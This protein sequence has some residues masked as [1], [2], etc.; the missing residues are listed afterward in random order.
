MIPRLGRGRPPASLS[1]DRRFATA[2]WWALYDMGF[3]RPYVAAYLAALAVDMDDPIE[4]EVVDEA[5]VVMSSGLVPETKRLRR[6][7]DRLVRRIDELIPKASATELAWL[8]QSA[9]M[10]QGMIHFAARR[11][12]C[13]FCLARDMLAAVDGWRPLIERL[14]QRLEVQL[15]A[16]DWLEYTG[17]LS[18][19]ARRLLEART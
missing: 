6:H 11:D 10:I 14:G 12:W 2:I 16:D 5:L 3:R 15:T 9:G 13:A 17:K 18:R 8:E 19:A 1:D 4:I 7:A